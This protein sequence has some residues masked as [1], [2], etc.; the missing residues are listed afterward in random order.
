MFLVLTLNK[1]LHAEGS[2]DEYKSKSSQN[3]H[4]EKPAI[5]TKKGVKYVQ[6]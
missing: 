2:W 1:Y 3:L 6:S 5:E 4:N